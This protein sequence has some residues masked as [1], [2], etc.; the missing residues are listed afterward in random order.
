MSHLRLQSKVRLA[1]V[2]CLP[3]ICVILSIA[4]LAAGIHRNVFGEWQFG[5]AWL[6]FM[7]HCEASVAVMAGS[8]PT[9]RAF[10]TAHR[11]HKMEM[12]NEKV[13]ENL[14]E[15][16]LWVLGLSHSN[17]EPVL[18]RLERLHTT[19]SIA[20]WRQSVIGIM[21]RRPVTFVDPEG[22]RHSAAESVMIHPT[23]AYH[24]IRTK[25]L[26]REGAGA[27]RETIL[28]SAAARS[29]YRSIDVNE[30]SS[31]AMEHLEA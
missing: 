24:D 1:T 22:Q 12:Q 8:I 21:P 5:M 31:A 25:E 7:L 30:V 3:G 4:R 9:L 2:L 29:K 23:L 13:P 18:P 19:T 10:Y 26:Q 6:S 20:K 11:D 27:K 15:K 28:W 14:K 16:A 17:E